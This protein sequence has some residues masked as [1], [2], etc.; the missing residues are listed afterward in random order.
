MANI[1]F[2]N[3]ASSLLDLSI[4][5]SVLT[6]QVASGDGAKFPSPSGSQYFVACLEDDSGNIEYAKIESRAGD[7]LTVE[8]GGR[9]FDNSSAQSFTQ[10]ITRV[11][12]RLSAHV[13]GE[14][15]QAAGDSMTG[16]LNMLTNEIQNAELTGTTIIT[17]GQAVGMPLRGILGQASNELAISGSNRATVGGASILAIGDDL[18]PLLDTAGIID[19]TSATVRVVVGNVTGAAL[20]IASAAGTEFLDLSSDGTNILAAMTGITDF[21]FTGANISI[22]SDLLMVDGLLD[23]ANL[24]DFSLVGQSVAAATTLNIDYELGSYV[25]IS[26]GLTITN[27]N[28]TNPPATTR[29]GVIRLKLTQDV[30]GSRL[31]TNWPSGIK[32]PNGAVPTL[33]T[34][35][36]AI[37]F[38]ELWTDDFGTTWYG[39]YGFNWS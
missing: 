24:R 2:F 36:S 6:I 32:W 37:D 25:E 26:M 12:L 14:F 11:E 29:Y 30:T 34:D 19:L 8:A 4:N 31:V 16:D 20:R 18:I 1:L 38:V 3:N 5:A 10:N 35:A 13:V 28:I 27:L 15:L 9:G 39:D 7:V 22:D 17:G 21:K 33:T 23:R